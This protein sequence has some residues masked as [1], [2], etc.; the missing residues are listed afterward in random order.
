MP[1]IFVSYSRV[2]QEFTKALIEQLK[3]AFPDLNIWY[4]QSPDT[5]I[6]GDRWWDE[7]LKAI[8]EARVFAY[9]D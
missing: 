5:L 8:D 7:I 3:V 6:G 1:Q 9:V 2:D 4:D